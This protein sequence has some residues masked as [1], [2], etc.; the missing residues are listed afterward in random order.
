[1]KAAV[2]QGIKDIR[3]EEV[4]D[5]QAGPE[6]VVVA[7]SVCGICGSD[8]HTY[9][10]GSFVAPGQIMGHEFAGEVVEAGDEVSGLQVG[11]RV[12]ASPLVPCGD[13]PRCARGPLQP[14]RLGL[15]APGS[16]TGAPARS[17]SGSASRAPSR[18]RTS[19]SSPTTCRDE[20]GATVEPLAVA[21]H[22]VRLAGDVEGSTALVLGLGT[23]G[24][25]VVQV[26]RAYG[27]RRVIGIDLSELRLR[28][29]RHP[30]RR[31]GRRRGG[32]RRGGRRR[33]RS[34][35]EEVDVVFECS[36]VPAA[37]QRRAGHGQ[38]R[39]H[40]RRA[41]PLRRPAHLQPDGARAEGD[42]PA[43]QHRLHE[44]R[45]RRGR[46]AAVERAR[47]GRPAHHAPRRAR[48][49]RGGVRDP[50]EQGP[51]AE[52]PRARRAPRRP[53]ERPRRVPP[54]PVRAAAG[55]DRGRSSCATAPRRRRWRGSASRSST[56][57][58]TRRC[59]TSGHAQA[60]GGRAPP[61]ARGASTASSCRRCG[62]RT[63]RPRR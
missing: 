8:L 34:D 30:G 40:D 17:R 50:D 9:L 62:A 61:A 31:G 28:A 53:R 27:A 7:V 22:A 55:G 4:D 48:R 16:P 63:R 13:C 46:G 60:A 19:S 2:F 43:G 38:G 51:L 32:H 58:A 37:R 39:R 1:M 42:P 14:V 49:R 57:T 56:A 3:V 47:A 5:P 35:G 33:A 12:T 24:Q 54:A 21:V 29:A 45:L 36:G 44:R 6:D 11:D 23:I 52:G 10:H 18:A 41:R 59:R 25:Q 20:A 26:L 15:D